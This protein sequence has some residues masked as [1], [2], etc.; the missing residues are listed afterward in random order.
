MGLYALD[1]VQSQGHIAREDFF[2]ISATQ[3]LERIHSQLHL[4]KHLI[5]VPVDQLNSSRAA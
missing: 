2:D 5:Y 4:E 3:T 1:P